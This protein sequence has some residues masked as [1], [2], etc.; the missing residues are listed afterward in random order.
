MEWL[1]SWEVV[2]VFVGILVTIALGV[3]ALDDYKLAKLFFLLAAVDASGGIIMWGIRIQDRTWPVPVAVFVMVGSIGVLTVL[4]FWYAD[5]KKLAK[6]ATNNPTTIG[7]SSEKVVDSVKQPTEA[8]VSVPKQ[9]EKEIVE[10]HETK[11]A[12]STAVSP[13]ASTI[14][15]EQFRLDQRAWIGIGDIR[16]VPPLP[17]VGEN[18][19]A[20]VVF[21]NSGKTVAEKLGGCTISEPVKRG[22]SPNFSYAN[23]PHFSAGLV[24]PGSDHHIRLILTR[25]ISKGTPSP[26]T[27]P[28]LDAINAEDLKIY[29]HGR[30]SYDDIFGRHH[31]MTFCYFWHPETRGY[32]VCTEHNEM[33]DVVQSPK[34]KQR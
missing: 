26:L 6:E 33:D 10:Q 27:Q 21:H 17:T 7:K 24:A 1:F 13:Q 23:E 11:A 20:V 25:S 2:G 3:L 8:Q 15:V 12:P 34:P 16:S 18:L 31:W 19:E 30:I 4:A 28:L 5:S 9:P 14:A 32:A 22:E 29:I